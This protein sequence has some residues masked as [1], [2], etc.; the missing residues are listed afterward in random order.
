MVRELGGADN[1]DDRG[2]PVRGASGSGEAEYSNRMKLRQIMR[3]GTGSVLAALLLLSMGLPAMCGACRGAA[4]KADCAEQHGAAAERHGA[5]AVL[6]AKACDNC[7]VKSVSTA[8]RL[9]SASE[10]PHVLA[11]CARVSCS[12]FAEHAFAELVGGGVTERL[13][14]SGVDGRA[15]A[16]HG[17]TGVAASHFV[18][19]HQNIFSYRKIFPQYSSYQPLSVSLKI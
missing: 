7:G 17:S 4:E 12:E 14:R 10:D 18:A 5:G 1:A 8:A 6:D 2:H 9:R 13:E 11:D 19:S 3:R 16:E 15:P